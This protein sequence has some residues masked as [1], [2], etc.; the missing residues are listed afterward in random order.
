MVTTSGGVH[1]YEKEIYSSLFTYSKKDLASVLAAFSQIESALVVVDS[2]K[3]AYLRQ[4][5]AVLNFQDKKTGCV[6]IFMNRV[7]NTFREAIGDTER[8]LNLLGPE[9]GIESEVEDEP[10]PE[11]GEDGIG[12]ENE[13]HTQENIEQEELTMAAIKTSVDNLGK[14]FIPSVEENGKQIIS[15]QHTVLACRSLIYSSSAKFFAQNPTTAKTIAVV[16]NLTMFVIGGGLGLVACIPIISIKASIVTLLG[17]A[18]GSLVLVALVTMCIFIG[19]ILGAVAY[20]YYVFPKLAYLYPP[21][22][23]FCIQNQAYGTMQR[24]IL[25]LAGGSI[26]NVE[27]GIN[28]TIER[29]PD[30]LFTPQVPC[31][32]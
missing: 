27:A 26:E 32:N 23:H 4:R 3:L 7:N 6:E 22:Q 28:K 10:L 24:R 18:A 2:E 8:K 11:D 29:L 14:L 9:D 15:I 20:G 5:I 21:I 25:R 13:D 12:V 17:S 19:T 31:G 16:R 1:G 30:S